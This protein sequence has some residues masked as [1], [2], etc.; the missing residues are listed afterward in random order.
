MATSIEFCDDRFGA[1]GEP[2]IEAATE[3]DAGEDG[4]QDRGDER[5][6]AQEP[7]DADMQLRAGGLAPAGAPSPV[8]CQAMMAI[9]ASTRTRLMRSTPTTTLSVGLMGVRP[10][11]IRNVARPEQSESTAVIRPT[12]KGRRRRPSSLAEA[13]PAGGASC[14]FTF[15]EE[16]SVMVSPPSAERSTFAYMDRKTPRK[17]CPNSP[18]DLAT[19]WEC[20]PQK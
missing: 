12:A 2:I 8:T 5:D 14:V 18:L 7:D 15:S 3:R 19:S 9:I 10:V 16:G 13:V 1:F 17:A 20:Q 4:E 6:H 11:R